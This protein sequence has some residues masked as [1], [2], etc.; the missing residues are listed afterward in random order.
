MKVGNWIR[1]LRIEKEFSTD[2]MA[3]KLEISEQTY[4]KYESDKNS[5]SLNVLEKI[6]RMMTSFNVF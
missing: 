5:P 4:W 1:S 6:A 3:E 2:L